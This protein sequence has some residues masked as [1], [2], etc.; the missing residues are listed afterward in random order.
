M[1]RID[2][3][4]EYILE[5][6]MYLTGVD[7]PAGTVAIDLVKSYSKPIGM[8]PQSPVRMRFSESVSMKRHLRKRNWNTK[9]IGGNLIV[10][11][12]VRQCVYGRYNQKDCMKS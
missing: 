12:E 3:S 5:P 2:A 7:F 11:P 6:E 4:K 9:V 8:I 10:L 1:P